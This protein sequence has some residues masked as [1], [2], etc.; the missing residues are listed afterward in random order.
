MAI[1]GR[2]QLAPLIGFA[3]SPA[4]PA[5]AAPQELR[6]ADGVTVFGDYRRSDE[7]R[8]RGTILLFHMAG[9]NRGEYATIAPELTRRGFDTLAIDQRSGGAGWG[10]RNE[11]ASRLPRDPGFLPAL[12][13]LEAAFAW[14]KGWDPNGRLILWGSSYSAALVFLLAAATR[15]RVTAILA[16]S[17]GEYLAGQSVRGAAARV[18]SPTFV[19]SDADALEE[20]SAAVLLAAVRGAPKRQFRPTNGAHGS[21]ILRSDRNPR[22]AAVAWGAVSAFLDEVAP[23]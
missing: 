10:L 12:A 13:D 5:S 17:P 19:A 9:S 23:P 15:D 20:A 21:S 6:A 14:A 11:T 7:P 18:T 22:G 8:R 1:I 4:A 3:L 2:R 16:F